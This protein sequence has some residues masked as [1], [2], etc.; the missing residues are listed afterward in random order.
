MRIRSIHPEQWTASEWGELPPRTFILGLALRNFADD[1]GIFPWKLG[2]IRVS[3][4]PHFEVTNADIGDMLAELERIN[5][6]RR[7]SV[8]SV[9]YGII[10]NF[11][12]FQRPVRPSYYH[13]IPEFSLGKGYEIRGIPRE[14]QQH[15]YEHSLSDQQQL[16]EHSTTI[17]Q[18][19]SDVYVN[20]NEDV[21]VDV[22]GDGREAFESSPEKHS[23][24]IEAFHE[25]WNEMAAANGLATIRDITPRLPELRARL[26]SKPWRESWREA[27]AMVPQSDFLCGRQRGSEWRITPDFFIRP[28]SVEKILSGNYHPRNG[29]AAQ[30]ELTLEDMGA[31]SW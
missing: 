5:A 3:C 1:N 13:P 19:L 17:Q 10:R 27:L 24:D 4:V 9:N 23:A 12:K 25:A 7:Y 20:G 28:K 14:I 6:I 15:V 8:N 21:Y 16:A 22:N 30:P 29:S 31:K 2:E 26:K 18:P 11:V